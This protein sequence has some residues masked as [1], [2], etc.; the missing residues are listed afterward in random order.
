MRKYKKALA[1]CLAALLALEFP[2][3]GLAQALT[4]L[5]QPVGSGAWPEGK[6]I[7]SG[8]NAERP[9][10]SSDAEKQMASAEG[11]RPYVVGETA[12]A[13]LAEALEAVTEEKTEIVLQANA[14]ETE[15]INIE[16]TV[17]IC[18]N[19]H[20]ISLASGKN[21]IIGSG[22]AVIIQ[23]DGEQGTE[24]RVTGNIIAYAGTAL[25]V[26]DCS[27]E[28]QLTAHG[29]S[30]VT[31]CLVTGAK[32]PVFT[33]N[34][35]NAEVKLSDSSFI[36]TGTSAG[37][38][39]ASTVKFGTAD[40]VEMEN[41]TVQN[42]T[43]GEGL[44]FSGAVREA[45][46]D[47]CTIQSVNKEGISFYGLEAGNTV[48]VTNSL[49]S[50]EE[51]NA[52]ST[53]W[54][55]DKTAVITLGE[56]NTVSG[57]ISLPGNATEDYRYNFHVT[58]GQFDYAG[59]EE[60]FY[61][62]NEQG[63][64]TELMNRLSVTGG[65]F[66]KDVSLFLK[67]EYVCIKNQDGEVYP[68]QVLASTG[69]GPVFTLDESGKTAYESLAGAVEANPGGTLYLGAD[70]EL[71]TEEIR[72][73][74]LKSSGGS[75]I[76]GGTL[77]EF[78][79][80]GAIADGL[81]IICGKETFGAVK[82]EDG[83]LIGGSGFDGE[84]YSRYV[85]FLADGYVFLADRELYEVRSES[86][87]AAK[88]GKLGYSYF[89][90]AKS[91][92]MDNDSE[93][94]QVNDEI[95]MLKPYPAQAII[96]Q[97]YSCFTLDLNG[98]YVGDS[99]AK[100]QDNGIL[101]DADHVDM[102]IKNGSVYGKSFGIVTNGA[103]IDVTLMADNVNVISDQ[104][105]YYLPA[106]GKTMITRG[107][108]EGK[109]GIEVRGGMLWAKGVTVT[110][111][112]TFREV[113]ND[114]GTTTEGVGVAIVQHTTR[115]DMEITLE[116]CTVSG[117]K[118]AVR[119]KDLQNNGTE[120]IKISV[121]GGS[122]T[123]DGEE[124]G[125][126]GGAVYSETC[127]GFITG[128]N[129]STEPATLY[130]AEG[131]EVV[132][133]DGRFIVREKAADGE[134]QDG[135]ATL[136]IPEDSLPQSAPEDENIPAERKEEYEQSF[137]D[138]KKSVQNLARNSAVAGNPESV[139]NLAA[140]VTANGIVEE[141]KRLRVS[142]SQE[143]TKAEFETLTD[144]D[145][146]GTITGVQVLPKKLV[147]NVKA[148]GVLLNEKDEPIFGSKE[149][150]D[151]SKEKMS[152][153]QTEFSFRLPVPETVTVKYANVEQNGGPTVQYQ[154]EGSGEEKYITVRAWYLSE[155]IIT[156]TNE[157][158]EEPE[159]EPEPESRPDSDHEE[160]EERDGAAHGNIQLF[161]KYTGTW[162]RDQTGWWFVRKD[163]TWPVNSWQQ[164]LWN[165][166]VHWYHFNAQGYLDAGWFTDGDG[167]IY[168]LH[169][170]HDNRFGIMYTGWNWIDGRCY[171][172]TEKTS[173]NGAKEGAL[174][175]NT[176]T[177]DG[178]TVNDTGAWTVDGLAQTR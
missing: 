114:N 134:A 32:S 83:K 87:C 104:T 122:Y 107:S 62:P 164:C 94:I 91:A 7:P 120:N 63:G 85:E 14:E 49:V 40:T 131:Y 28:G 65:R 52:V 168:F 3:N 89:A 8:S 98:Q 75:L 136:T 29:S 112:G 140:A 27:V 2:G 59:E 68:Y 38:G 123:A 126:D 20:N 51:G 36:F 11:E 170:Q 102:T 76:F 86:V 35:K 141:D 70:V 60:L 10:T 161:A 5:A 108:A 171:Y 37:S 150:L 54:N 127:T 97:P 145:E 147:F 155:F 23:G 144:K 153:N 169:D 33:V 92:A 175:R 111:N 78:M 132:E 31:N 121:T 173:E 13:T 84:N 64:H 176:V 73:I 22:A 82:T 118:N 18:L 139:D 149:T 30:A 53:S 152:G 116:D 69:S 66:R 158:L 143:L 1:L 72:G 39:I 148:E 165:R 24:D 88:I 157:P 55:M 119:Q 162:K 103:R 25:T 44:Y 80:K 90:G 167:Q 67:P 115:H 105:A 42:T 79:E 156:F 50:S 16:K 81:S 47:G 137:E 58:G 15:K 61:N 48:T 124:S 95:V 178:Y 109:T 160:R 117:T 101:I 174:L 45:V 151:L 133:Q 142:L 71:G 57:R 17:T 19:G 163:G 159:P 96:D 172:F 166:E 100:K 4:V 99:E 110:G 9:V 154:M 34:N 146:N 177:P 6:T 46:I 129:F 26:E 113:P 125:E 138:A 128:G 56:G 21:I 93:Q 74:T 12:F 130:L 41:C 77:K 106:A 43:A 135:T